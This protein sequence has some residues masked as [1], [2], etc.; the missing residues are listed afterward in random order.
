M[1]TNAGQWTAAPETTAP[2]AGSTLALIKTDVLVTDSGVELA[3]LAR[4]ADGTYDAVAK[5]G[6]HTFYG[7]TGLVAAGVGRDD[8]IRAANT[9]IEA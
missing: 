7:R 3:Y 5:V 4:R 9:A 8:A 2:T 1:T 6:P